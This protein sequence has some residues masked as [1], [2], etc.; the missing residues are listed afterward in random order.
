MSETTKQTWTFG[1]DPGF[2]ETGICLVDGSGNGVVAATIK[3]ETS[4]EAPDLQRI[5]RLSRTVVQEV[6]RMARAIPYDAA[7][8][9]SL[10]YPVM[11]ANNVTN[12]RKQVTTL[13]AF[14]HE[15]V[16]SGLSAELVEVNPTE[17]KLVG[18][19]DP[20]ATKAKIIAASPFAGSGHTIETMADAWA[21]AL[22]GRK[23]LNFIQLDGVKRFT[24]DI[25]AREEVL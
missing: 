7:V 23:L 6:V 12:Y 19:G 1:I 17:V 9:I 20:R 13:Y 18:T 4:R 24:Y 10:E 15:L 11:K 14:E 16:A 3:A 22:A 25:E 8:R 2:A 21:I 5:Y